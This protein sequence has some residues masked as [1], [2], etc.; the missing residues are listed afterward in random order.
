[1]KKLLSFILVASMTISACNSQPTQLNAKILNESLA[2]GTEYLLNSQKEEGNFIYEYNFKT[3]E[4]SK[5]DNQV[6]QAGALWGIALIHHYQPSEK[7]LSAIEKSL[8][9]FESISKTTENGG[10][11]VVY[12]DGTS[13]KSGTIALITLALVDLLES[14]F[15][16]NNREKYESQLNEYLN[17]LISLRKDD[18][19]FY[20]KFRY[21]DGEG[22]STPSPY[23]DGEALLAMIRA[24]NYLKREDLFIQIDESAEQ[25]YKTN[26]QEALEENPDSD[27]TKGF[28]QWGIMSFYE[29][30]N[31]DPHKY[32]E[33]AQY[34]IELANWM[35]DV[36]RTLERTKNT[37]YAY[38]GIVLAYEL[39][40]RMHE[41]STEEKFKSVIDQGLYKLTSW[42]VGSQIQIDYIENLKVDDVLAKGGVMNAADEPLLRIDVTQHQ[43]H[44]VILALEF[45][46]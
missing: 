31:K 23:V 30:Y 18:G 20:S 45:V 11:Y 25:M 8:N 7:T 15:K 22:Y 5:D 24:A 27:T 43:M 35:I 46:Y 19:L 21:E 6:R 39:A 12:N 1:M 41:K 10:R 40:N 16:I 3:K 26:V 2:L 4:I 33:Y 28:F 32:K 29:L 42:Q 14:N 17:F 37:S 34:S 9:Y 38:E 36:H 44:A 13:G